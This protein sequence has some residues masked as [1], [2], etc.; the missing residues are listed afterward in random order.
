MEGARAEIEQDVRR[1]RQELRQEV[2]DLAVGAAE[3]LIRKSL[4]GEEHR[5]IVTDAIT[6]LERTP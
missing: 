2:A 1:A 5:K 4:R 3:R 6:E